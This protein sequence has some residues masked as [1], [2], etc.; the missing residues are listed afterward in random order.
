MKRFINILLFSFLPFSAYCQRVVIQNG[1][2]NV[3][4]LCANNPIRVLVEGC[5]SENI[6]LSINNGVVYDGPPGNYE[7]VPAKEGYATIYV[8]KKTPHGKIIT[9][10]SSR[11][12]VKNPIEA[13]L[14]GKKGGLISAKEMSVS[15]APYASINIEGVDFDAKMVID[16]FTVCVIRHQKEIFRKGFYS[17][18]VAIFDE[19]TK[20]FFAT[21]QNGDRLTIDNI[22]C[23]APDKN[24]HKVKPLDFI[25][26]E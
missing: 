21:L 10:D 16:S 4:Y 7:V 8:K 25:I 17:N 22:I 1:W 19:D 23:V 3:L 15:I 13:F 2:Q 5:S 26:Y 11:Y 6:S 24:H 20:K 14:N 18:S 9:I 12:R